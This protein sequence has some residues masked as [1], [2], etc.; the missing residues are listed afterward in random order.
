MPHN[1][2]TLSRALLS[3]H[4]CAVVVL[5]F[6]FFNWC[7]AAWP[8]V[9]C[10][11]FCMSTSLNPLSNGFIQCTYAGIGISGSTEHSLYYHAGYSILQWFCSHFHITF[12]HIACIRI[13]L[14]N[15]IHFVLTQIYWVFVVWSYWHGPKNNNSGSWF[16]VYFWY[17]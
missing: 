12:S 8:T 9:H 4:S 6:H 2:L 7:W 13:V 3:P 5:S 15:M 10:T 1:S 17:G 16:K 14:N 11:N